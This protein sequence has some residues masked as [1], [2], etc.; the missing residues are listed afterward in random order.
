MSIVSPGARTVP[1]HRR[2]L[3]AAPLLAPALARAQ[4]FETVPSRRG[5]FR[6][7]VFA[8]GLENPWGGGFLPDGRLLVTERPGRVRLVSPEGQV[9]APLAGLPEVEDSGQGGLL[10]I[11]PAPDFAATSEV[12][13]SAATRVQ[14]GALT[15]LYRARL[16]GDRLTQVLAVV[17]AAPAQARGR[18]HFGG[19]IAF[20]PDGA[21]LFLT[22]GDRYNER[23]RAQQMDDL[24]GKI[25][26]L[27]RDGRIP[28]DNPFAGRP[29]HRGEIWTYGHRNPQ[30]IAFHPATG[31][32]FAAEFGPLGGDELNLLRPG[33]QY[34]WP[35]VS[36]GREYSGRPIANGRTS[37]PGITEPVKYWA[38]A[39]SPS[40]LAF[41]PPDA[42]PIWRGSLFMAC[43]NTPGLLRMEMDGDRVSSEER[44]LW[45]RA[46]MRH[47]IFA[48]D[49]ALL[50][51][52]DE[53][54]GRIL[55]LEAA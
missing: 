27:T 29:G 38:P 10:D 51:L 17:D 5:A 8:S 19:R 35:E 53:P 31:S 32:L 13:F 3:F 21:H 44:L 4:D 12:F 7:R 20:S 47:V 14:G 16:R 22:C 1:L 26:R 41:A 52:T 11:Q 43:L 33:E 45:G 24:A 2:S 39:V 55:R 23:G 54:R 6:F 49:G 40:G 37:G 42:Q 15:R 36:Y 28:R 9:S 18:N 46:R 50:L 34:G 30:G 25:L 48:P